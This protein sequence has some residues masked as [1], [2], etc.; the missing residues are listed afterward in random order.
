LQLQKSVAKYKVPCYRSNLF[1]DVVFQNA[2][3]NPFEDLKNFIC[4][5]L[6]DDDEVDKQ[7]GVCKYS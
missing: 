7:V 5:Q 1:Y 2:M 3:A 4:D 6:S